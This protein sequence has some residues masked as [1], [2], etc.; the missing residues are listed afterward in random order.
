MAINALKGLLGVKGR[1]GRE[2]ASRSRRR[3]LYGGVNL[4]SSAPL[5]FQKALGRVGVASG[6]GKNRTLS[7]RQRPQWPKFPHADLG[8]GAPDVIAGQVNVLPA[9]R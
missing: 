6:N 8:A 9:Q 3:R 1:L 5:G 7:P 4:G 2:S